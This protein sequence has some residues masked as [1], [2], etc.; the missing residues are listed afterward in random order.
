MDKRRLVVVLIA[1]VSLLGLRTS[2]ACEHMGKAPQPTCCCK[3][4][5]ARCPKPGKCA[6]ASQECCSTALS[7]GASA[8][9]VAKSQQ[10]D[11]LDGPM[12]LAAIVG[13]SV[14]THAFGAF[15][16]T[17]LLQ[18]AGSGSLTWLRTGR[19]RL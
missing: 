10:P 16:A 6:G 18:A 15:E 19:L 12:P 17:P 8:E 2:Y 9:P 14:S 3:G 1:A 11:K 7:F 13:P 4:S 5:A